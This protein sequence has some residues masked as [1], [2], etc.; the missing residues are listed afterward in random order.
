MK[1]IVRQRIAGSPAFD[2]AKEAETLQSELTDDDPLETGIEET[3]VFALVREIALLEAVAAEADDPPGLGIEVSQFGDFIEL[4]GRD[5]TLFY[6]LDWLCVHWGIEIKNPTAAKTD[7]TDYW[8]DEVRTPIFSK[9]GRMG[10]WG[11]GPIPQSMLAPFLG[12]WLDQGNFGG[13]TVFRLVPHPC[14]SR[15]EFE[16]LLSQPASVPAGDWTVA[17]TSC[18]YGPIV[19]HATG[20]VLREFANDAFRA[21]CLAALPLPPELAAVF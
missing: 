10:F 12:A 18:P 20:L 3:P 17:F 16:A 8:S 2:R 15:Q 7:P 19:N 21:F 6:L 11:T 4:C 9:T 13:Q 5:S 1:I 14:A